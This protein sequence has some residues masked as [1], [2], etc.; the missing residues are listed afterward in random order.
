[1][2]R[3]DVLLWLLCAEDSVFLTSIFSFFQPYRSKIFIRFPKTLFATEDALETRKHGL[4]KTLLFLS[5]GFEF[6]S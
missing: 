1:M 3:S 6:K 2:G 4:G 5:T